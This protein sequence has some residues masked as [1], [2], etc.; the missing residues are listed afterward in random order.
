M[1]GAGVTLHEAIVAADALAKEGIN[2][3]VVDPFTLKPIDKDLLI[4]SAKA[5]GGR[6]LTVEDHYPEGRRDGGLPP[7]VGVVGFII[8]MVREGVWRGVWLVVVIGSPV[9]V[10]QV[11]SAKLWL[12]LWVRRAGLPSRSWL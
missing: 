11:V 10:S 3:R 4:K 9:S 2:I 12:V 6:L 1:V 5:T 7:V 8:L